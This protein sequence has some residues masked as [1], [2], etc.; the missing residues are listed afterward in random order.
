[1]CTDTG[2]EL[3]RLRV[4]GGAVVN[5]F[6]MQFQADVLGVEVE[7]PTRIETTGLWGR[8]PSGTDRW[9]VE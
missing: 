1:M 6:L 9:C 4:D 3:D 8:I 7:R 2:I 5:N